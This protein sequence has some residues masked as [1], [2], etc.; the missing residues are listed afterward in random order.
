MEVTKEQFQEYIKVQK[1]GVANMFDV[2]TVS[3]YSGLSKETV[4]AIMANYAELSEKF[5][6][7][8]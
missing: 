3:V 8:E 4:H 1:S 5:T 6:D 7:E 2:T